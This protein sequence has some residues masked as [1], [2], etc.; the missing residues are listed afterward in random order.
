MPLAR[1]AVHPGTIATKNPFEVSEG[2][3]PD[4]I[5][6][7]IERFVES[8]EH[9]EILLLL[10]GASEGMSASDVFQKI[11]SSSASVELRLSQLEDSRL[12]TRDEQGTFWFNPAKESDRA[13][14]ANLDACYRQMRVRIIEAIYSRKIDAIQT[15]ADAF[16]FR[17]N[18]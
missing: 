10:F 4:E 18:S 9:L 6:G 16:R 2:R 5:S 11:Q 14:V 3:L 8:V 17:R 1:Q 15:F 12:I 13:I 7:F